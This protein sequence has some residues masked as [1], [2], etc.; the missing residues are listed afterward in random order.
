MELSTILIEKIFRIDAQIMGIEVDS[1]MLDKVW[2]S[3]N[4]YEKGQT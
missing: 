4:L 1:E 2:N 3:S